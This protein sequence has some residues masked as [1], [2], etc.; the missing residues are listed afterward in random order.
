MV[1]THV[2]PRPTIHSFV[3]E[4]TRGN[5]EHTASQAMWRAITN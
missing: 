2:M 5:I 1:T 3:N 4:E